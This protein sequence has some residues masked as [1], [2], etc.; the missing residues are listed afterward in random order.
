MLIPE[1]IAELLK[2]QRHSDLIGKPLLFVR[3]ERRTRIPSC[4]KIMVE[5]LASSVVEPSDHRSWKEEDSEA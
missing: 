5:N 1:D 4:N 2:V 3:D